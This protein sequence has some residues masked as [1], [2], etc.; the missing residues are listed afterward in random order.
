MYDMLLNILETLNYLSSGSP[1]DYEALN[2]TLMFDACQI[3]KCVNVTINDDL[4]EEP[5]ERFN[6]TL[7]RTPGLSTRITLMPVNGEVEI[8]DDDG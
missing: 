2:E 6:F 1:I 7:T 4:I 3:R 8:V 5:D